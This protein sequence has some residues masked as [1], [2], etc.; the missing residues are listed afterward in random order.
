MRGD[1]CWVRLVQSFP[2]GLPQRR[3]AGGYAGDRPKH[4]ATKSARAHRFRA[5]ANPASGVRVN[6]VVTAIGARR[7]ALAWK[8]FSRPILT[9]S[10]GV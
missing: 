8:S 3:L 6:R 9:M 7:G 10:S 2:A 5:S 1:Y 4:S